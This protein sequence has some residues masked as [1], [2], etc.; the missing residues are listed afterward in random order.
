MAFRNGPP[1][2]RSVMKDQMEAPVALFAR[3][4][5][6][7]QI[8][9]LEAKMGPDSPPT[10]Y[11]YISIY[12]CMHAVK[13]L[14]GPS[15]GFLKVII[16]SKV[17]LLPGPRWFWTYICGGFRRLLLLGYHLVFFLCPIILQFSKTAFVKKRGARIGVS[18]FC[19]L[20]L[21]FEHSHF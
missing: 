14:S 20:S 3:Q 6:G 2:S 21:I 1:N 8:P 18:I 7:D 11:I 15:L 10:A 17:G 19:V 5:L 4:H 9:F 13:L 16:W 12:V